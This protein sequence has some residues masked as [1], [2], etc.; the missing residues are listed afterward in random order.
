MHRGREVC[1]V[2]L[3]VGRAVLV[4]VIDGGVYVVLVLSA[5]GSFVEPWNE[6]AVAVALRKV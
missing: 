2:G 1:E 3:D 4:V 6:S 5:D